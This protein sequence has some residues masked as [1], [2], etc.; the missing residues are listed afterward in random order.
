MKPADHARDPAEGRLWEMAAVVFDMDGVVTDT[1]R[2]HARA[3]AEM[4]NRF[5]AG[6]D[7]MEDESLLQ[8][9]ED[10]YLRFVDGK[11]RYDGV[12]SFLESRGISLPEGHPDDP[13]TEETVCGLGNR[14]NRRFLA[15][16][17]EGGADPYP[18]TVRLIEQL[19]GRGIPCAIITSSRNAEEVL[20]S[21]GVSDL[22]EVRVDGADAAEL[23]LAG[24]PMPDIFVEAARRLGVSPD[25][26]A[27]VEDAISGVEAGRRGGFG[28]VIGVDRGDH[29]E[30][31]VASGAD[32]VVS[33]LG[34]LI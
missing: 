8:F 25:R 34:E 5:L 1:A 19:R 27:V 2:S 10:D 33:D 18:T 24:K 21:A 22:F 20:G 12:R 28:L 6:R 14:K 16:L 3:W 13:P 7:S 26:C 30:D 31:L 32:V 17:G 11:P 9:T 4:F 15:L 23:G 29:A